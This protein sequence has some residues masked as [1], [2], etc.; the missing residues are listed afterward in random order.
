ML[1]YTKFN[2]NKHSKQVFII[3]S[4]ISSL[5]LFGMA[6]T[7]SVWFSYLFYIINTSIYQMLITAASNTIAGQI[8]SAKYS[9]VFGFNTFIALVLQSILTVIVTKG[10]FLDIQTQFIVYAA[11]FMIIAFV[12]IIFVVIAKMLCKNESSSTE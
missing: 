12:F 9:L 11:Y 1:Q 4:I 6:V 8:D 2:W 10:L 3:S 5:L 7:T